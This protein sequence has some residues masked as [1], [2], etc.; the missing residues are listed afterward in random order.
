LPH[1]TTGD[2]HHHH[3]CRRHHSKDPDEA[4]GKLMCSLQPLWICEAFIAI[5]DVTKAKTAMTT[6]NSFDPMTFHLA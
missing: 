4:R 5:T 1:E 3:D 2:T 6:D